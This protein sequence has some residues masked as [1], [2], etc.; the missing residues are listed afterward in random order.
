MRY[1]F[2]R[3]M[4]KAAKFLVAILVVVL[5]AA[6]VI[7][8]INRSKPDNNGEG[9]P[10]PANQEETSINMTI[11][12]PAFKANQSIPAKYTCDGDGV[13]PPLQFSGVPAQAKS[14]ALIVDDP[15]APSGDWTHWLVW[16]INP[17]TAGIAEGSTPREATEGTTSFGSTGYGGPCPPSGQHHYRF[18]LYALDSKLD[19]PTRTTGDGLKQ[20]MQGHIVGQAE[21]I[22]V[23]GR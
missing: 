7:L 11:S 16:N 20:A 22:G 5:A 1:N 21:V 4:E 10:L 17:E 12:S 6:G 18:T 15:D 23:Y 19:L 14:L 3:P 13:N 2:R 8:L 9:L